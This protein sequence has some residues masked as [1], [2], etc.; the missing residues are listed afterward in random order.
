MV[1]KVLG[2]GFLCLLLLVSTSNAWAQTRAQRSVALIDTGM[3]AAPAAPLTCGGTEV[4]AL[5][6]QLQARMGT[7]ETQ[8]A[9]P[10]PPA[11]ARRPAIVAVRRPAGGP[12]VRRVGAPIV[13]RP[14]APAPPRPT[15]A[16]DDEGCLC[17]ARHGVMMAAHSGEP[18]VCRTGEDVF[19][20]LLTRVNDDETQGRATALR[21]GTAAQSLPGLTRE[22]TICELIAANPGASLVV[23]TGYDC[24]TVVTRL[25]AAQS[26]AGAP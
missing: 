16:S 18:A 26:A 17:S 23:P 25:Q 10:P 8:L 9:A 11:P 1:R 6:A 4:C 3:R 12:L 19:R 14:V 7:A 21:L 24:S 5:I 20:T 15:C 2:F 22:S 13:R